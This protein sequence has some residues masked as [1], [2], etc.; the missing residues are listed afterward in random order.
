MLNAD[1]K[2][3][4]KFGVLFSALFFVISMFALWKGSGAWGWH[5]A[6]AG[7]FLLLGVAAPRI[8]SP[9]HWAWMKF[10]FALGWFNTRLFLGIVF[11]FII[12][13]FGLVMRL[14][15]KD[16]LRLKFDRASASYWLIRQPKPFDP[17]RSERLF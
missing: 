17:K 7:V 11:F 15:R 6:A 16:P 14:L 12:T 10:A 3:A 8:L 1:T 5:L 2:E 9:L 4:R 13:P